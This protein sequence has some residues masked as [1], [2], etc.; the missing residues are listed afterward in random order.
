M[1]DAKV[2]IHIPFPWSVT[3]FFCNFQV[4][5]TVVYGF[6]KISETV[7]GIAKIAIRRTFSWSVTQFFR[8]F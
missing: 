7:M 6:F 1:G 5:F 4:T 2:A 8:N 3:Q